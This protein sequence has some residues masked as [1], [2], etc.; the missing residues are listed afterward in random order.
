MEMINVGHVAGFHGLKGEMKVKGTSDFSDERFK[1]KN[2]L[3]LTNGK[4]QLEVTIKS[5]RVHK[6]YDLV[7]IEGY[8]NLNEIEKFRGYSFKIT[9]DMLFELEEDEY[10]NFDLIGLEIID[11]EGNSRGKVKTIMNLNANDMFVVDYEGRDILI[12]FVSSIVDK[13]NL[14][15][16]KI[17]L[18]EI[19]GLW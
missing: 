2:K 15:N 9:K 11:F 10:Y 7:A 8:N 16:K 13:V 6:G 3:I 14:E 17:T 4:E 5:H 12:P 1:P 19:D 18:F